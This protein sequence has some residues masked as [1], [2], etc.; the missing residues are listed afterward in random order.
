[1][2]PNEVSQ[3]LQ[4]GLH[5]TLGAAASM[6]EAL[7]FPEESSRKF[8]ELGNDF[9]RLAEVLE[10]KGETT[11]K[12]A[13]QLVDALLSQIPQPFSHGNSSSPDSRA[14]S[15]VQ[16]VTDASLQNDL[17]ALTEDLAAVRRELETLK[18]GP[19]HS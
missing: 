16:P 5:L 6:V 3:A 15:V 11:E 17:V 14:N 19:G 9:S 12:E 1:M 4:K 7:Q 10:A 13:R 18:G 2:N 8:A